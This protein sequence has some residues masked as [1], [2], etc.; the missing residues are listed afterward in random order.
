MLLGASSNC[1]CLSCDLDLTVGGTQRAPRSFGEHMMRF[2]G[3][4]VKAHQQPVTATPAVSA[5]DVVSGAS[6]KGVAGDGASVDCAAAVSTEV[7]ETVGE[8]ARA[9]ESIGAGLSN[10]S[11]NAGHSTRQALSEDQMLTESQSQSSQQTQPRPHSTM[12]KEAE[13]KAETKAETELGAETAVSS[14]E[15]AP[16]KKKKKDREVFDGDALGEAPASKKSRT[17]AKARS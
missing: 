10:S 14:E 5:P 9:Q 17:V 8:T 12:N 7:A 4:L 11:N 2:F 6:V 15:K 1:S 3:G 16:E 13:T